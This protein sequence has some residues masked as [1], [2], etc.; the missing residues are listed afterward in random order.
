MSAPLKTALASWAPSINII[1]IIIIIIINLGPVWL[2]YKAPA[3][4][5]IESGHFSMTWFDLSV[6]QHNTFKLCVNWIHI[7]HAYYILHIFQIK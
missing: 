4:W 5:N 3:V 1:I 7:R 6:R 2:T